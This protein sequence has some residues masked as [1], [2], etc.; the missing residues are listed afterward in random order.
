MGLLRVEAEI[1]HEED[2][3]V[4]HQTRKPVSSNT[5]GNLLTAKGIVLSFIFT[6]KLMLIYP[7]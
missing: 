7:N 6:N 3:E 1:K 5:A 4:G 2:S